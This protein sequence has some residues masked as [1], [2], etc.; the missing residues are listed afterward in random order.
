MFKSV[1][2]EEA[3]KLRG[4]YGDKYW[5]EIEI[6]NGLTFVQH[7]EKEGNIHFGQQ[8]L[9][10]SVENDGWVGYDPFIPEAKISGEDWPNN[11]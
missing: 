11:L 9:G 5:S 2:G 8:A 3:K 7:S 1:H 4:Y 6:S 10:E